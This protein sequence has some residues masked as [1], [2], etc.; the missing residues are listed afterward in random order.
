MPGCQ[1]S[2]M[3]GP[4]AV[5]RQ[6]R[7]ESREWHLRALWRLMS[8]IQDALIRCGRG[9]VNSIWPWGLVG[10][11]PRKFRGPSSAPFRAMITD[12]GLAAGGLMAMIAAQRGS[13]GRSGS[14][15]GVTG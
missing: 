2:W 11:P 4:S 6:Y 5:Y 13:P 7:P 8:V 9:A 12:I 15:R 10:S 3:A 1:V 14:R